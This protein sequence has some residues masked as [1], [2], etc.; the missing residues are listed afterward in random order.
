[1]RAPCPGLPTLHGEMRF[2]R[3]AFGTIEVDGTAYEHDVVIDRG[4]VKKR[5]KGPSQALRARYGHTPLSLD[6]DIPWTC[7]RLVIGSGAAGALPVVADVAEE[8]SR[9][10]VELL[11][12]P[13]SQAIE[14]L[15]RA[16]TDTNAILHVTC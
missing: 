14:E 16:P 1:M 10:G 4:E 8:A 7:R 15:E 3:F 12:L 2:G 13:T 11:V 9:R 5:K 6:E